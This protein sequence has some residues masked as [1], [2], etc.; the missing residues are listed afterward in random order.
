MELTFIG[1]FQYVVQPTITL[2]IGYF[3][4][5]A[6]AEKNKLKVEVEGMRAKNEDQEIKNQDN[7]LDLYKKLHD[8]LAFRLTEA[9]QQL[10]N[11]KRTIY[12]HEIAFKKANACPHYDSCPILLELSKSKDSNRGNKGRDKT[13]NRQREPP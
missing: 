11:L 13:D 4:W 10:S 6:T 3:G 5:K 1:V 2:I 7:W 8:D 12:K 9:E